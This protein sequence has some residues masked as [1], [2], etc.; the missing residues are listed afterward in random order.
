LFVVESGDDPVKLRNIQDL[1]NTRADIRK[2]DVTTE[3]A[4][5]VVEPHNKS[6]TRRIEVRRRAAIHHNVTASGRPQ[7]GSHVCIVCVGASEESAAQTE[8]AQVLPLLN[9]HI[10]SE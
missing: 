2:S 4:E 1:S 5:K 9:V 10:S 7:P 8:N 3:A 6:N